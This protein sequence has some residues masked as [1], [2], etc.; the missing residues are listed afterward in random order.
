MGQRIK[1]RSI[2]HLRVLIGDVI[3]Q[4]TTDNPREL[5]IRCVSS[6]YISSMDQMIEDLKRRIDENE[7]EMKMH[8]QQVAASIQKHTSL[9][10]FRRR[11]GIALRVLRI[12][13][14]QPL[15]RGV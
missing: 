14:D 8:K 5:I 4:V 11:R 2:R 3:C 6:E 15:R 13:P 1:G 12:A 7:Q 10:G 9:T